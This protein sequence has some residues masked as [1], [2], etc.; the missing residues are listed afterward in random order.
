MQES[1]Q[2]SEIK[3]ECECLQYY[4]IQVIMLF[5]MFH[6]EQGLEFKKYKLV[7]KAQKSYQKLVKYARAYVE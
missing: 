2:I 1:L 5:F 3:S 6:L 7:K 4:L